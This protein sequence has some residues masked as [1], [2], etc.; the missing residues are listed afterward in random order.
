MPYGTLVRSARSEL[1]SRGLVTLILVPAGTGTDL[2]NLVV[3]LCSRTKNLVPHLAPGYGKRIG[4][5]ERTNEP[6]R[7]SYMYLQV[8]T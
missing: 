2:L 1:G 4:K 5:R 8:S 7:E 3:L 6:L